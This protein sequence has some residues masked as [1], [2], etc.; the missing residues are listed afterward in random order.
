MTVMFVILKHHIT[1]MFKL[2]LALAH[3][4]NENGLIRIYCALHMHSRTSTFV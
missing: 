3:E 2:A 1:G 4:G